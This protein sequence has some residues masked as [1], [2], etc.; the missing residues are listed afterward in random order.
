MSPSETQEVTTT[1]ADA[2]RRAWFAQY[3]YTGDPNEVVTLHKADGLPLRA[4]AADVW[5]VLVGLRALLADYRN[6]F[7]RVGGW[8]EAERRPLDVAN[9]LCEPAYG[10]LTDMQAGE[11][12]PGRCLLVN[13]LLERVPDDDVLFRFR[14]QPLAQREE[15]ARAA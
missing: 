7:H 14:E 9:R 4:T 3:G 10:P 11:W 13:Y 8:A 6:Q 15:V 12:L 1:P 5:A 2:E